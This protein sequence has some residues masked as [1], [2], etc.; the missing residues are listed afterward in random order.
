MVGDKNMTDFSPR[1][2]CLSGGFRLVYNILKKQT[3]INFDL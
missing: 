1:L 2:D 3:K